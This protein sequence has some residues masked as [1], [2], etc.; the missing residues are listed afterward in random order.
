MRGK[1]ANM[2]GIHHFENGDRKLPDSLNVLPET[3]Q[4]R[5]FKI[6]YIASYISNIIRLFFQFSN[7]V[8]H[9]SLDQ[10]TPYI[11]SQQKYIQRWVHFL[12]Q[13]INS[14]CSRVCFV[15][16]TIWKRNDSN[17]SRNSLR[18]KKVQCK[19]NLWRINSSCW[20]DY[21]SSFD[22]SM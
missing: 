2:N 18:R 1:L 17:P 16:A 7:N 12:Q 13:E 4:V 20:R 11:C 21:G 15:V 8:Y 9:I 5:K 6:K 22:R 19:K 14:S 3:S 10:R